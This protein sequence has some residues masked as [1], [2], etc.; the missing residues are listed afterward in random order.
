MQIA[1]EKEIC[2]GILKTVRRRNLAPRGG[3]SFIRGDIALTR[4]MCQSRPGCP[5][6]DGI[7]DGKIEVGHVSCPGGG[8]VR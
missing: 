6:I 3:S 7:A 1:R 4:G 5:T 2:R 8:G